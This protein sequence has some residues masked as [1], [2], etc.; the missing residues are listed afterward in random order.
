M[1]W[2][3]SLL[4]VLLRPDFAWPHRVLGEKSLA[5][6]IPATPELYSSTVRRLWGSIHKR[7]VPLSRHYCQWFGIPFNNQLCQLPFGLVL[8]WSD[9]TRLEEVQAMMVARSAG[10]PVPQVISYG[11]HPNAPHAP[12]SILM[13]RVPGSELG[14]I[15]EDLTPAQQ[16]AIR[17]EMTTMLEAIRN[18]RSPW[19]KKRICSITGG[20]IRSVRVPFHSIGPCDDER[21]FDQCL[22]RTASDHGF[23][24]ETAFQEKLACA[25]KMQKKN[26]R[27]VFTHGDFKHH[28][29][30]V[31][32]GHV[33][34]FIDW[35][36]AG[37]YPE[38]WDYTTALRY[39]PEN[40]WWFK[41]VLQVGG[42]C[43]LEEREYERALLNLTVDSWAW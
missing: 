13:T 35:E 21:E 15:Y 6:D 38:Y 28:N 14:L 10:L 43:Y 41:F 20:P 27:I 3:N 33:S 17:K 30:M 32:E 16:E 37:W 1:A 18:W 40:F 42:S 7:L 34:G 8:K 36:S 23:P 24:S 31:H 4:L 5:Q 11:E 26:H 9:G 29:I 39:I 22:I 25:K 12:V 2:T 19:G